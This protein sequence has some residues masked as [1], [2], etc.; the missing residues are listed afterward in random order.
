MDHMD[1]VGAHNDGRQANLNKESMNENQ[2]DA[3]T[4]LDPSVR[5]GG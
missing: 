4:Y 1:H 2:P 3:C 5:A